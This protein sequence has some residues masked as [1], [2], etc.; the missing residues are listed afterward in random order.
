VLVDRR[1]IAETFTLGDFALFVYYLGWITEFFVH[2]GK[3]LT[4]YQQA[5]ISG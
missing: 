2:F 3:V 4:E 5:G 1:C